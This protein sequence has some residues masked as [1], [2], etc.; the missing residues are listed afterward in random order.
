MQNEINTSEIET[1]TGTGTSIADLIVT[2]YYIVMIG[3][4]KSQNRIESTYLG[5]VYPSN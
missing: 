4:V 3:R 2:I 1:R 5:Q